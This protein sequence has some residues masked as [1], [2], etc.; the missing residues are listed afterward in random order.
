MKQEFEFTDIDG[1]EHTVQFSVIQT[2]HDYR[3][4]G[5]RAC[6]LQNGVVQETAEARE[7]FITLGE[8]EATLQMLCDCQVMPN[9]LRD[10]I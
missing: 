8:A 10:V 5:I 7:R 3:V 1:M 6:M 2:K 4:Y 9:T